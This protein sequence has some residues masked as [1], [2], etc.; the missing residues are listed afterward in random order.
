MR[1][2]ALDTERQ[3]PPGSGRR[4]SSPRG[5]TLLDGLKRDDRAALT[6]LVMRVGRGWH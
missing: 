3:A 6:T 5:K 4:I 2:L 1:L